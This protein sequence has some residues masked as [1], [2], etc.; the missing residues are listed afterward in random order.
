MASLVSLIPFLQ[1]TPPVHNGPA[2]FAWHRFF[3]LFVERRMQKLLGNA[4]YALPYWEWVGPKSCQV[5][6]SF[7][8]LSS[9][10]MS[11]LPMVFFLSS[12][13]KSNMMVTHF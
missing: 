8:V 5:S 9:Q 11:C 4:N 7:H 2:F 10:V 12:G 6:V 13:A 1:P 3:L